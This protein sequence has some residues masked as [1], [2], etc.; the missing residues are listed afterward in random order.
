MNPTTLKAL[1]VGAFVSGVL[2]AQ[3]ADVLRLP[4]STDLA[5]TNYWDGGVLP[6]SD[7]V[8]LFDAT[9]IY[10]T[11][12]VS[13]VGSY[14]QTWGFGGYKFLNTAGPVSFSDA[15]SYVYGLGIVVSNAD[16]EITF[17]SIRHNSTST[18]EWY[19]H[20]NSVLRAASISAGGG[21]NW[22][23]LPLVGGGT[24]VMNGWASVGSSTRLQFDISGGGTTIAGNGTW[25]PS[26]CNSAYGMVLGDGS[27]IAPGDISVSNT[28]GTLT[29]DSSIDGVPCLNLTSNS[30]VKF[31][32]GSGAGT[33]YTLPST[34]SDKVALTGM[35]DGDVVVEGV[36]LDLQFSDSD[37][38][39]KLFDTDGGT[40]T[41]VGL[42][43]SGQEII[44]GMTIINANSVDYSLIMG[45]GETGD[46]G[47]IYLV[48]GTIAEEYVPTYISWDTSSGEWDINNSQNWNDGSSSTVYMEEA[49]IGDHV[50]FGELGSSVTVTLNTNVYPS[51]V[52][53]SSSNDYTFAEASGTINGSTSLTKTGDG[54]LNFGLT[55]NAY[56]GGTTVG[57]G[58][59]N[60]TTSTANL[61]QGSVTVSNN[62]LL[63]MYGGDSAGTSAAGTFPSELIVPAG[64]TAN[65]Y[66]HSRGT[67]SGALT[68][69]GTVNLQVSYIRGD[70]T[71]NWSGFGGQVNVTAFDGTDDHMRVATTINAAS[72]KVH[73]GDGV[74]VV[75]TFNGPKDTIGT[76]HQIGELSGSTN[77]VI[78]GQPIGGRYCNWTVGALNTD[79][80]YE[81]IIVDNGLDSWGGQPMTKLTKVG[82]GTLTMTGTNTYTGATAVNGGTLFLTGVIISDTFVAT[83][84]A[85]GGSGRFSNV[86]MYDGAK[87]AF[88]AGD[89]LMVT[90]SLV[91][92]NTNNTFGA[93]DVIADDWNLVADGT[94]TLIDGFTNTLANIDTSEFDLGEGRVAYLQ[95]TTSLQLVLGGALTVPDIHINQSGGS[96]FLSWESGSYNVM[97]NGSLR[98]GSWG[99]AVENAVS[100]AEVISDEPQ[101][102]FQLSK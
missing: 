6:G 102:F 100:P 57:G 55:G 21:K 60:L 75:Q 31:E 5:D 72:A 84:A 85:V 13:Y 19:I 45:D 65:V 18:A 63:I 17:N 62:A 98:G 54:A 42:T 96:V 101:L 69:A 93:D 91:F 52:T 41:W 38:V 73:I 97:T 11:N 7:N 92:S 9:T 1:I 30:I 22:G 34:D 40:N 82:T 29:I 43:L 53:V 86:T 76:I 66:N 88:S 51:S 32:L 59:L 49:G 68:G 56:Y 39:F 67:W 80:T 10:D 37:G 36:I 8:A 25:Q 14:S 81:G 58:T 20:T 71:G 2:T 64:E 47:D 15:Y 50:T 87:F 12:S 46:P 48:I 79:S 61:G 26:I 3:G 28:V 89:T 44:G 74:Y 24:L 70:I 27:I 23:T 99:V 83:N 78:A 4:D 33:A 16:Y 35:G 94:Y 77:A 95:G 90:N